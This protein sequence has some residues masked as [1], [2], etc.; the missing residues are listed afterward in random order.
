[1]SDLH[2]MII[3][4]DYK[5][6]EGTENAKDLQRR[7]LEVDPEKRITPAQILS[8]PWMKDA[9]DE[10]EIFTETEKNIIAKEFTYNETRRLNRN[11]EMVF[12]LFTEHGLNSSHNSLIKNCS[13]KSVMP[14]R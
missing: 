4:G 5:I 8:H 13:T 6:K 11:G 9:K 1:M 12:E 14:W 10:M 7:M 3:K 2:K